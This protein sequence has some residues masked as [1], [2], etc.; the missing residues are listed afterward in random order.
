MI[1]TL[2]ELN[3]APGDRFAHVQWRDGS[4]DAARSATYEIRDGEHGLAA[5][6]VEN[7]RSWFMLDGESKFRV[8]WRAPRVPA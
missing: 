2:R 4:M 5:Y 7:P 1:A 3:A 6:G 8:V